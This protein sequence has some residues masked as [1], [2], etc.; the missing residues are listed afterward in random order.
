MLPNVV[1]LHNNNTSNVGAS[2]QSELCNI[3]IIT[4]FIAPAPATLAT[5]LLASDTKQPLSRYPDKTRGGGR[6][7]ALCN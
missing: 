3:T 7:I 6:G 5:E 1:N 2:Q 4:Y